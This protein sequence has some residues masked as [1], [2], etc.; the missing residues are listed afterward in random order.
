M[1]YTCPRD[2]CTEPWACR[3]CTK[4]A[5]IEGR[6]WQGVA[7]GPRD[8]HSFIGGTQLHMGADLCNRLLL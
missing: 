1:A 7:I 2:H 4:R 5:F 8:P 3:I 6:C